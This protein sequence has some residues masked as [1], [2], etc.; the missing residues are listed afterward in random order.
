MHWLTRIIING[1]ILKYIYIAWKYTLRSILAVVAFLCLMIVVIFGVVQLPFAQSYVTK[2]AETYFNQTFLGELHIGQVSGFIPFSMKLEDVLLLEYTTQDTPPDTLISIQQIDLRVN[3]LDFFKRTV[4]VQSLHIQEP[5]VVVDLESEGSVY[6]IER[7]FQRGEERGERTPPRL[8]NIELFAPFLSISGGSLRFESRTRDAHSFFQQQPGPIRIENIQ[9][10]AFAELSDFQRYLDVY[11]LF[12]DIP[13]WSEHTY[14]IRGQL[15]NDNR[16]LELNGLRIELGE[17]I[18]SVTG[19]A[20]PVDILKGGFT[21]QIITSS[22]SLLVDTAYVRGSDVSFLHPNLSNTSTPLMFKLRAAG[23]VDAVSISQSKMQ[24]GGSELEFVGDLQHILDPALFSYDGFVRQLSIDH[25]DLF[26]LVPTASDFMFK[27]WGLFTVQGRVFGDISRTD[28]DINVITPEGRLS[29]EGDIQWLTEPDYQLRLISEGLNIGQF[30][31][32]NTP[33]SDINTT[34]LIQGNGFSASTAHLT[35]SVSM[36]NSVIGNFSFNELAIQADYIEG[37][38]DA[39]ISW[40]R[41]GSLLEFDLKYLSQDVNEMLIA[42]KAESFDFSELIG[43]EFLA[44]TNL[45]FTFDMELIN[46]FSTALTGVLSL[47]ITEGKVNNVDV[48]THQLYADF[49]ETGPD[50]RLFRFT[51]TVADAELRGNLLPDKMSAMFIYWKNYIASRVEDEFTFAEDAEVLSDEFMM[52]TSVD[53]IASARIK[54]LSLLQLYIPSLPQIQA[55]ANLNIQLFASESRL[56]VNGDINASNF[57]YDDFSVTNAAIQFSNSLQYGRKLQEFATLNIQTQTGTVSR[58]N[59]TLD[60]LQSSLSLLNETASFQLSSKRTGEDNVQ[61]ILGTQVG[62]SDTTLAFTINELSLGSTM[63]GWDLKSPAIARLTDDRK[64]HI[65]EFRLENDG[66][67]IEVSGTYS[68]DLNDAMEYR[69]INVNLAQ[70]SDIID[71]RSSFDGILDGSFSSQS[72][73]REPAVTGNLLVDRFGLDG[74]L[75]GDVALNSTF[76]ALTE[77]FNTQIRV[78]TNPDKYGD[79][80]AANRGVGQDIRING[81][82]QAPDEALAPTDT[83]YYFDVDLVQIDGWILVPVLPFIFTEAEGKANGQGIITG[84]AND[85][86]F[87]ARFDVEEVSVVPEFVFTNYIL[88]GEVILDRYEGVSINNVS[89]RDQ[90]NGTGV[91]NGTVS[92]NDFQRERPFDLT[93]SMNRLQFLN[94]PFS[95]D[96]PFYGTVAGTGTVSLTGSNL[97]PFLRT[98]IPI[99]TTPASRLTIPLLAETTV[100]EQ[101]RFI[102]FVQSF[103]DLLRP[104]EIQQVDEEIPLLRDLTFVEIARLDLQ[105]IA[106]AATTVQLLFDPLTGEVL[107]ARGSGRIRI[108]LEDEEFQMFGN[109]NVTSGEYTFVAGDVFLRRFQIRNGGSI[110]WEGDPVNAQLNM[111]AAYRARPNVSLLTG[112]ALNQQSRIPVDLILEISGT[113]Q[114]IENDFFFEFPNAVDVTQNATELALLNSEDQKLIQATSLLFTGSFLPVSAGGDGQFAELGT[115]LQS[116]AGQ[117]GL[118][119]LLSNQIN[120]LLNSNL[121]NLDVDLNLT[122]FDQADLG[123]ALRLFN[124]RLILRG[125]SQFYTANETGTET[126][127]GDLGVT[128]RINRN[129]S[130][131]VFHRRDP[132]LR[133]IVGNQTQAESINGIGLE[134]QVQFNTWAELRQRLWG[135]IRRIFGAAAPTPNDTASTASN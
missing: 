92:F 118:S 6:R 107:N 99:T 97:S 117:V 54:D 100:E 121:S 78:F 55:D 3:P 44:T 112:S 7:A 73:L 25:Q 93:L 45:D 50:E 61:F 65:D 125:E 11:F 79:Y 33:S 67:L 110:T 36:F 14:K 51:S 113:I 89:V 120:T 77:R 48:G 53:F 30:K 88:S 26:R 81:W 127:L 1:L 74:R 37:D 75:V 124:D 39:M 85:F 13:Q 43:D 23:T 10:S 133:S 98:I 16:F 135:Q 12:A 72:L 129:L 76:D 101:A 122:G 19:E 131:E 116:R 102:E 87:N 134:A 115:S 22:F 24:Y 49:L 8:E 104:R 62:I 108:T 86:Y 103:D 132:T 94:S 35:A 64:F 68:S 84:N 91:L 130:V 128:Y 106:P 111:T 47:D 42:G 17:S 38:I 4:S 80:L 83:L 63:Y 109:F 69:F 28:A 34:V 57:Q 32:L 56:I 71:G 41:N 66:Q 40:L 123:I 105:F 96:V 119:Q 90:Q 9:F 126:L 5:S 52:D 15:F 58:G 27:D 82:F 60:G 114:S 18:I 70:I 21:D 29:L 2:V 20:S 46:P 59:F 95:T 31:S